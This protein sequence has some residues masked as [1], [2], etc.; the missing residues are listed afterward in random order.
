M[1]EAGLGLEPELG[2]GFGLVKDLCP[3]GRTSLTNRLS[4]TT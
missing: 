3:E 2:E 1:S 4:I